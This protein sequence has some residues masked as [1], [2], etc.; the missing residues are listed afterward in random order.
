[1][2]EKILQIPFL[3]E[4]SSKTPIAEIDDMLEK[5]AQLSLAFV[6]WP[7]YDARPLVQFSIAHSNF[8]V[9][10]RYSVRETE[11]L[12]RF[13]QPNEPVY[14]DSA[15]EF[16]IAFDQKGYY[17]LEFNSL[18]TCLGGFG[19]DRD[20]RTGQ[21]AALLK[22]I[23]AFA[24]KPAPGDGLSLWSLT[25]LIPVNI[26]RFDPITSLSGKNCR[27][28]FYKCGDDLQK[29]QYLAWNNI[30]WPTPNFHLPQFFGDAEFM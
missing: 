18:G 6:P 17:N 24:K 22:T 14:R 15:V 12:A 2:S 7:Q 9:L 8:A 11:T 23:Q 29:P 20:H 28:N 21:P 1:M 5:Q 19:Q 10:L 13:T 30:D 26:F 4:V 3:P 25:L 27:V 16:F